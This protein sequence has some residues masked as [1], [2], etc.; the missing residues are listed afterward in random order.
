MTVVSTRANE[1]RRDRRRA[2]DLTLEFDGQDF[3][4]VDCSL[5]G[6]V[7]EGG[8]QIFEVDADVTASLRTPKGEE[9]AWENIS[10]RVVRIDRE[11]QR[12]AFHFVGMNDACFTALERHLT[13]RGGR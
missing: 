12:V 7:V 4:I 6:I 1:K 11:S 13:G 9:P 5:G 3:P 10:F 2:I 8:C